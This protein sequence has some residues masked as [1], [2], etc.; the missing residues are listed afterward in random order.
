MQ[1]FVTVAHRVRVTWEAVYADSYRRLVALVAAVCGSVPEAEEAVQ[2]A[3]V[4]ALGMTGRRPVINEP[5]AW[6]Y[7]VAINVVR[8]RWR[9]VLVA[10]RLRPLLGA[11]AGQPPPP[12]EPR[13]ALL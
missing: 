8:A 6:L 10:G 12:P 1:P 9:R 2:E 5:E 7:R 3:F 11:D 13:L 4:R